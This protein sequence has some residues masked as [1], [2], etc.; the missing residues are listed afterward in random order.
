M[1]TFQKVETVDARQFT[2]GTDNGS[3]LVFWISSKAGRAEYTMGKNFPEHIR[4][5][6]HRESRLFEEAFVGDWLMQNQDGSFRVIRQQELITE[7][8]KQV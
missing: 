3:S 7:G 1:A 6:D 5:Y 8:Y 2:G 4:L